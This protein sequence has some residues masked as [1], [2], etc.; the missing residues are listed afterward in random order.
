MAIRER[1]LGPEHPATAG[2]LNNL[3]ALLQAQGDLGG[4][5][6]R[7]RP[8]HPRRVL[9]PEHPDTARASTTAQGD[10]AGARPYTERALAI[11]ERVL[12]P[13]HPDT[14]QSLNNLG[15]L[16][17]TG[18]PAGAAVLRAGRWD[19]GG[20]GFGRTILETRRLG[21]SGLLVRQR[22]IEHGWRGWTRISR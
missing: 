13:E 21:R 7:A 14:A 22:R 12:G 19:L 6:T 1:V 9:G 18:R 8:G 11:R 3:G 4:G 17:A 15:V 2:S 20:P 5:A 16:A 10:L